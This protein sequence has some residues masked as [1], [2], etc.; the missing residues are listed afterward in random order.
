M[1][2]KGVETQIFSP[3]TLFRIQQDLLTQ[4]LLDMTAVS[5]GVSS[6]PFFLTFYILSEQYH[7]NV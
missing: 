6:L 4:V 7:S 2:M 3:I 5:L 1:L